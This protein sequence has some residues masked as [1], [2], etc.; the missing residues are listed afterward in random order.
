MYIGQILTFKKMMN[1]KVFI[2]QHCY[3]WTCARFEQRHRFTNEIIECGK[4][5]PCFRTAKQQRWLGGGRKEMS[6]FYSAGA[7]SLNNK[8][9]GSLD[10][11]LWNRPPSQVDINCLCN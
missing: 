5:F 2:S 11:K 7:E 9:H 1:A 8:G 4:Y 3:E 6:D 10:L